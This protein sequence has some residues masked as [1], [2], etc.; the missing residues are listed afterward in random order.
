V[1][2]LGKVRGLVHERFSLKIANID[3]LGGSDAEPEFDRH[4][5]RH[6]TVLDRP[7]TE[8][9]YAATSSLIDVPSPRWRVMHPSLSASA[10]TASVLERFAYEL[11]SRP[12]WVYIRKVNFVAAGRFTGHRTR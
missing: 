7:R 8:L 4:S 5:F 1:G 2:T 9:A 6:G 10:T 3:P 12:G 11:N